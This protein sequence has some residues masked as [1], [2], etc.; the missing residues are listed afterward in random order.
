MM[1]FLGK[2][3]LILGEHMDRRGLIKAVCRCNEFR[4]PHYQ[5]EFKNPNGTKYTECYSFDE[6]ERMGDDEI[7]KNTPASEKAL[8]L[9]AMSGVSHKFE[10]G[11]HII[12]NAN[13]WG[14]EWAKEQCGSVKAKL[15]VKLVGKAKTESTKA[16]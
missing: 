2:K 16:S 1:R 7:I 15:L 9:L 11:A 4:L 6:I 12:I 14:Q 10:E 13:Y 8:V 3:M 5:V